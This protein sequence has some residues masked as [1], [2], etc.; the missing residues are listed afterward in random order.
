M[1]RPAFPYRRIW[2]LNSGVRSPPTPAGKDVSKKVFASLYWQ[3]V[4]KKL[5]FSRHLESRGL[6]VTQGTIIDASI[7][8]APHRHQH[9]TFPSH[10]AG[11]SLS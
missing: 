4:D 8:N 1:K 6:K 5:R 2:A 3:S 9:G 11:S 7:I 10:S